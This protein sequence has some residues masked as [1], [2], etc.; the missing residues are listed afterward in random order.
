MGKYN[1]RNSNAKIN[2]WN[3]GE[4][5]DDKPRTQLTQPITILL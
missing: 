1:L 5:N 2:Q 3:I 4:P